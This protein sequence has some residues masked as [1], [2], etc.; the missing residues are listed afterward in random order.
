MKD[1]RSLTD[2][3]IHDVHPVSDEYATGRRHSDLCTAGLDGG[4][5]GEDVLRLLS[6]TYRFSLA[7][8]REGAT[9]SPSGALYRGTSLVRNTHPVGPYSSPLPRDLW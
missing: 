3:A 4:D 9:G 8:V 5:V 2:L 7:L 6:W 1:L